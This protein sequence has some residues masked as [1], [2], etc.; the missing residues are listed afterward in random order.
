MDGSLPVEVESCVQ[1]VSTL[2]DRGHDTSPSIS[3]VDSAEAVKTPDSEERSMMRT[4]VT[5]MVPCVLFWL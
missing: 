2:P 5:G 4:K 3:A 1:P